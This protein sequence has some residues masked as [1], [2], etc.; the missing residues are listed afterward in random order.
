MAASQSLLITG[1][2]RARN[3]LK[4]LE[5]QLYVESIWYPLSNRWDT[6]TQ[7]GNGGIGAQMPNSVLNMYKHNS[8]SGFSTVIP[9]LNGLKGDAI[10]GL[11]QLQ[12][13][14]K[15]TTMQYTEIFYNQHRFAYKLKDQSVEGDL[16]DYFPIFQEKATLAKDW[17]V[18]YADLTINQAIMQGVDRKQSEAEFWTGD[19]LS[20]PPVTKTLHPNILTATHAGTVYDRLVAS[21]TLFSA[22]PA[23]AQTAA[24]AAAGTTIAAGTTFPTMLTTYGWQH[25][26]TQI[27]Y[28]AYL[29][30]Q[31]GVAGWND[32]TAKL[33]RT[34][35]N[36]IRDY[37][38]Q[39]IRKLGWSFKGGKVDYILL[40]TPGQAAD[41]GADIQSNG[42]GWFNVW[43]NAEQGQG[44]N[45]RV[46]TGVL[47]TYRGMALIVNSRMPVID[48]S[49]AGNSQYA[50]ASSL[51]DNTVAGGSFIKYFQPGDQ[52]MTR[53]N[54]TGATGTVEV[55]QLLGMGAVGH[56]EHS[57]W[58]YTEEETDH[59]QNIEFGMSKKY[60]QTRLEWFAQA[61]G[62]F[63]SASGMVIRKTRPKNVSSALFLTAT[64]TV[65]F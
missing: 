32:T 63:D 26:A 62:A 38:D 6:T 24:N 49:A 9:V 65:S 18:E 13:T 42:S 51:G 8:A 17:Q 4:Q 1:T 60:G 34:R 11:Q 54:K 33:T 27:F 59:K 52:T 3:I 29:E 14:G 45:G 39:N 23:A 50:M 21:G 36:A 16:V 19:A 12:G 7:I 22:L 41:L 43:S 64:P 10:G 25:A 57:D 56:N 30:L 20:A 35:L 2:L 53:V 31:A 58:I 28:A 37:A 40:I 55:A 61:D 47:G 48:L 5:K 44:D 46:L 15:T